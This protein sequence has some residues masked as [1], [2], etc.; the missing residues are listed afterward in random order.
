MPQKR[1]LPVLFLTLLLDMIGVG[2]LIPVI[3]TLFTEPESS[4]FLL[5]GFS[6]EGQ[7]LIAGLLTALFGFMQFIAAP[8]LGELSDVYGRKKLLT[9]GV[10]VLAFSQLLFAFG[11]TIRSLALLF[12]SR[13]IA[14]I[15]GANFSIAQATIA[16]VTAP[17][18]RARNFGL[19]G[20]A[21]GL[22]F[23][24]GPLLGGTLA[25]ATGNPA[26]PFIFAGILGIINVLSVSF[27]LHETHH[28]RSEKKRLTPLKALHNIK[29]AFN[30]H[31]AR[32]LYFANF[33]AILG[34]AFY[35]SFISIYLVY[36]FSFTE[37]MAGTY[38]A[39]AGVWIIFAQMVVVRI[40]SRLYPDRKRL[41]F[42]L[43]VLAL[44]IFT[45]PFLSEEYMLYITMPFLASSFALVSTGFPALVSK[46]VGKERQGAALGINGSLQALA[47][48][49]APLLSGLAAGKLGITMSFVLGACS[50]VVSWVLVRGR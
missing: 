1:I 18:H 22:G 16:D 35:T 50:V 41:L 46:G 2:M 11:I 14:G 19:I 21:F 31:D 20:A 26:V 24:L 40:L 45:I 25:G 5:Q 43:P 30:D 33:F 49:S 39:I 34:F 42:A 37:S 13:A 17:E 9:I 10:G 23:I 32:P 38:F 29:A 47:Q 44:T 3:P 27:F 7:Y 6:T 8:I 4:S 28:V 15:A 48:A 36:R 12:A